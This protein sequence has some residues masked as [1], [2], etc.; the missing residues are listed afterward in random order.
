MCEKSLVD[1]RSC[2]ESPLEIL[3]PPLENQTMWRRGF[4]VDPAGQ[5][6]LIRL[7]RLVGD[8]CSTCNGGGNQTHGF[9]AKVN[10]TVIDLGDGDIPPTLN[11]SGIEVATPPGGSGTSATGLL[12]CLGATLFVYVTVF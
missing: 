3:L 10:G 8:D 11:V 12:L 9:Y 6:E 7:G 4:R 5:Q 1:I 2:Y